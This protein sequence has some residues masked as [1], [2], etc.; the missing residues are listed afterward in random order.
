M[1]QYRTWR[2]AFDA[3]EVVADV[4]RIPVVVLSPAP[5]VD[6][7]RAERFGIAHAGYTET[8]WL[9]ELVAAR[10]DPPEVAG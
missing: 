3:A 9:E 7:V 10:F 5:A 6:F 8:P 2:E 4:L 1:S